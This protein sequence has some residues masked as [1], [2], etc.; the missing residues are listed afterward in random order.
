MNTFSVKEC[1]AFGWRTFRLRPWL[2]VQAGVVVALANFLFGLPGDVLDSAA[3]AA[4]GVQA[5]QLLVFAIIFGLISMVVYVYLEMGTTHFMLKA[6]DSVEQTNLKDLIY[7]KGFWR[8]LGTSV[9]SFLAVIVGLILLIVPGII[10]GLALS[11][12]LFLVIDKGLGPINAFKQSWKLTKGNRWKL[13][14]LSL[15]F[16]GINILGMLALL[17]GLLVTV[18]V[19]FLALIHA[20][21]VLSVETAPVSEAVSPEALPA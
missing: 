10:I 14:L 19:T 5:I 1:I 13:F 18:P 15:A 21:R 7:L 11:F 6:H 20:Y 12:T 16:L 4:T 3:E 8:Y 9:V 17:V 2:F